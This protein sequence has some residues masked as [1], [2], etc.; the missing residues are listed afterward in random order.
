[1]R[2]LNRAIELDP[3][4]AS[5]HAMLS[6]TAFGLAEDPSPKLIDRGEAHARRSLALDPQD[7]V[8]H[9]MLARVHLARRQYT[10]AVR[11]ANR[12][13]ELSPS[14]DAGYQT[15]G[16]SQLLL[17]QP[18]LRRPTLWQPTPGQMALYRPLQ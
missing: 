4:F 2:L 6:W 14:Y 13:V 17:G 10:D 11:E 8:G 15:L 1:M 5:A 12:S 18:S 16:V 9:H 3:D 7:H